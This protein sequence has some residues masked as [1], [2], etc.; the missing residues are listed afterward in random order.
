MSENEV[1]KILKQR[2]LEIQ[3]TKSKA[4]RVAIN[5][6]EGTGK[7][8]FTE[9]F[10]SYLHSNQVNAIHITI[11]GFHNKKQIRYKQGRD[12]AKGYYEDS[13]N[14]L[15]FTEKV[16]LSSQK[17]NPHYTKAVHNLETDE[18]L[19]MPPIPINHK[20]IIITDGAY[21]FKPIYREHW[22]LKIYL[23]TDFETAQKRGVKRDSLLLGGIEETKNKYQKRYHKASK[24]Y[25]TK[26]K[27]EEIADIIIDNTNFENLKIK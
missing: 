3:R 14:E 8:T 20:S 6:I 5:G 15:A 21:L 7:T 18:I 17:E 26:N 2:V 27:A 16:L 1:F 9:K 19:E 4:V 25:L 12:S 10:T 24:I 13:Y 22:D 11:D 23:K